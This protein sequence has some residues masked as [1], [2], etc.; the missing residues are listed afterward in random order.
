MDYLGLKHH[1][2]YRTIQQLDHQ[3]I[4]YSKKYELK[5]GFNILIQ[6]YYGHK[7]NPYDTINTVSMLDLKHYH[8]LKI[9]DHQRQVFITVLQTKTQERN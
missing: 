6:P 2:T 9:A 1:D 8:S 7:I 3:R 5:H 4:S